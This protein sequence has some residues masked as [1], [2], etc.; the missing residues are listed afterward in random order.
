MNKVFKYRIYSNQANLAK[1]SEWIEACRQLYN[2]ALEQRIYAWRILRRPTTFYRQ[3]KELTELKAE[4]P[5]LKQIDSGVLENV[6]K[7]LDR[8]YQAFF[9]R[10]KTGEKPG[11]PR[12]KG[13]D[14]YDSITFRNWG[15]R[16]AGR[17]LTILKVGKFKIKL[18]RPI[19]GTIKEITIKRSASNKWF[20]HFVCSDVP[21]KQLPEVNRV[22]GIDMGCES[23]L[24]D[25][26]GDKIDNPRFFKRSQDKLANQQRYLA[27][28]IRG[29]NRRHKQKTL[30][31]KTHEKVFN[32][33]QDFHYK[34][35]NRLLNENG[36]ICIEKLQSWNTYRALNKSMRDVAWF[37]FFAIL[38]AK[39]EEAGREIIE[40]PAKNTS[41]KCS[42]CGQIVPKDLA[43]RIHQC[44]CG[45]TLDRDHNAA[46]NILRA[47]QALRCFVPTT[48]NVRKHNVNGKG[49]IF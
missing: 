45:L 21:A 3:S 42:G 20:I 13:Q 39:A 36:T 22:I 43:V 12:F 47:G 7:R 31:A 4:F 35:A 29:S 49:F 24:T 1:L 10:I 28:K 17:Y 40:V 8:S 2:L 41:Q 6:L 19:E 46:L 44:S 25:S 18:S 14:R 27:R 32:Q 9:R 15:W 30:V 26:N 37:Q 5:Q 48:E 34:V 23:F 11:F 33:R 16:L 38:K